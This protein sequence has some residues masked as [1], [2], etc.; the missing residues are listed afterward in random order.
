MLAYVGGKFRMAK[1][2]SSFIPEDIK[3]YGEIFGGAFWT[4]INS[5]LYKLPS[6]EKVYYNDFNRFMVNLINCSGDNIKF[7]NHFN[8][9]KAQDNDLFNEYRDLI[10]SMD[11]STIEFPDY[12]IAFKYAYLL[13]QVFSGLGIKKNT[14]MTDLKG[15]YKSKFDSFRDRLAKPKMIDKLSMITDTYNLDFEKAIEKLDGEDTLLYMDPPYYN[16]ETYYSFHDFGRDDHLRL[17]NTLKEMKGKFILSYYYFEDLEKWFPKDKY[18]WE[19]KEF[20]KAAAAKKNVKTSK[21]TEL[22][23]MNY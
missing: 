1:W 21:G 2:I 15:K 12:D 19:S 14:K 17:A 9:I 8:H 4:Y 5:E 6:L 13:T 18:K 16:T 20:S 22:L 3:V 7:Q 10:M 11:S 23:I